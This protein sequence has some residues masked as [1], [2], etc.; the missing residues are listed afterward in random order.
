MENAKAADIIAAL[1]DGVSPLTGEEFPKNSVYNNPEI[2]RALFAAVEALKQEARREAKKRNRQLPANAGQPWS[3]EEDEKLASMFDRGA[4][5]QELTESHQRTRGAIATR[6]ERLGK[7][8]DR[9]QVDVRNQTRAN[10]TEMT[11]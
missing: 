8:Q 1:A 2:I 6:L 4:A 10:S 7:I 11:R 9:S 3:A 5:I